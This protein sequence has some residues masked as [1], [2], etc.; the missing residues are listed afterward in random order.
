[1]N[2]NQSEVSTEFKIQ[3]VAKVITMFLLFVTI[4]LVNF[5]VE[6]I[7]QAIRWA[8]WVMGSLIIVTAIAFLSVVG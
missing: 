5:Q 1:M 4:V 2:A 8:D 6:T 7:N 3:V